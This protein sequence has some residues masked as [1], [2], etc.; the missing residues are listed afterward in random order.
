[1]NHDL[2][3][4]LGDTYADLSADQRDL[5]TTEAAAIHALYPDPDDQHL[6]DAALSATVQH[7]LG[8]TTLEDARQA[9]LDARRQQAEAV[10]VSK[11]LAAMAVRYDG[12]TEEDAGPLVG[13][14]RMAV[15]AGLGKPNRPRKNP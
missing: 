3:A 10:A 8:E 13:L 1:M 11:Q 4:W 9:L 12:V 14:A 6:R 5:V 15:R 2:R 7:L